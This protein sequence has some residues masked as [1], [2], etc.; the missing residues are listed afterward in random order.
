MFAFYRIHYFNLPLVL[1]L[2]FFGK[3][4][5]RVIQVPLQFCA[6]VELLEYL[7]PDSWNQALEEIYRQVQV[8]IQEHTRVP[9]IFRVFGR[10]IPLTP[11][12]LQRIVREMEGGLIFLDLV[13]RQ[14][15]LEANSIVIIPFRAQILLRGGATNYFSWLW[16]NRILDF[17]N[18]LV[19]QDCRFL[20]A[21]IVRA[22]RSMRR[23][24]GLSLSKMTTLVRGITPG[25]LADQD[26]QLD[27][28]W[29][30]SAGFLDPLKT[31]FVLPSRPNVQAQARLQKT[32]VQWIIESEVLSLLPRR[33]V[34]LIL[35]RSVLLFLV[36][37]F[38]ARVSDGFKFQ[39]KVRSLIWL[40]IM[41][42]SSIRLFITSL[43]E[44]WPETAEVA[45]AQSLGARAVNWSYAGSSFAFTKNFTGFRDQLLFR[46]LV[47]ANENWTWTQAAADVF[48]QRT[49]IPGGAVTEWIP[50]GPMMCGDSSW[51]GLSPEEARIRYG[52]SDSEA[53]YLGVFDLP[54]YSRMMRAKI[55][56]ELGPYTSF[57]GQRGFFQGCLRAL[58][59]FSE[60]KILLKI[61]R[62]DPQLFEL[63]DEFFELIDSKGP[64]IQAGRVVL[65]SPKAD[66]YCSIAMSDAC[67]TY[68]FSSPVIACNLQGKPA[69]FYDA[70]GVARNTFR[71]V[72]KELTVL[73]EEDLLKWLERA[74][75]Q[76]KCD[77]LLSAKTQSMGQEI[78]QSMI[79]RMRDRLRTL[80][81]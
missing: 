37:I 72:F 56:Y 63:S 79:A 50:M 39:L 57:E 70:E 6:G 69:A 12:L 23:P 24:S 66:P 13:R 10:R 58:K 30:V 60:L 74:I 21:L 54:Y 3:I 17:L 5:A 4:S 78:H 31:L 53:F 55:G 11:L 51:L 32:K 71:G 68:P 43:G 27:F 28:S 42:K 52:I 36:R 14:Q 15:V 46:S 40:S 48:A 64:W 45:V 35:L 59:T 2:R 41:K 76:K 33:E 47:T 49:L 29:W 81:V 9:F 7:E 20:V 62:L 34:V 16:I 67:I 1:I 73:T 38:G 22:L 8:L 19:F 26:Y 80:G 18:E 61:K 65:L 44:G 25:E 77:P 75:C